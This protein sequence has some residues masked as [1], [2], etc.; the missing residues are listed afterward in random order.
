MIYIL[1]G[2]WVLVM[3]LWFLYKVIKV[4]MVSFIMM[5]I[6]IMG[7]VIFRLISGIFR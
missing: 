5:S 3:V 1:I 2:L 7:W 6:M 4:F